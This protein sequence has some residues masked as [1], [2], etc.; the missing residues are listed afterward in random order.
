M[1]PSSTCQQTVQAAHGAT[2]VVY[3]EPTFLWLTPSEERR[4]AEECDPNQS[5]DT[6]NHHEESVHFS[7][8]L[9]VSEGRQS[10]TTKVIF[11]YEITGG[12]GCILR[13]IPSLPLD[14]QQEHQVSKPL[15]FWMTNSGVWQWWTHSSLHN[16]WPCRHTGSL[17]RKKKKTIPKVSPWDSQLC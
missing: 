11:P 4:S 14:L 17:A 16:K 1:P 10:E 15:T 12:V 2:D 8:H 3:T 9:M 13:T 5:P 6:H 7:L